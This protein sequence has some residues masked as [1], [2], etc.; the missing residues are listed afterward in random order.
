MDR[1]KR[2]F[3]GI[4][5]ARTGDGFAA[6]SL[7]RARQKNEMKGEEKCFSRAMAG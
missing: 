6:N 3:C 4:V 1:V 2:E 7:C 5:R